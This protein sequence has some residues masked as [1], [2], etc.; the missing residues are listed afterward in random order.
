[1][2]ELDQPTK[3]KITEV[4]VLSQKNRKIDDN[5]GAKI[6]VDCLVL[7]DVLST[8]DGHLKG[9][10]YTKNGG[11]AKDPQGQ[12][13]GVQVVSDMPD[14]TT[15]GKQC[16]TIKWQGDMTGYTLAIDLGI[17]RPESNVDED[18]CQITGMRITPKDGGSVRLQFHVEAPNLSD[19]QW[20]KVAHLK[21]REVE[22]A[23]FAPDPSTQRDVEDDDDAPAGSGGR[24]RQREAGK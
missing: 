7:N 5:P 15:V 10:L 24:K 17:G 20:P 12:L 1:M 18:D 22:L 21:A 6:S 9:V 19:K 14:L 3:V 13:D 23:L 8:F 16:G 11:A 2:F 4:R